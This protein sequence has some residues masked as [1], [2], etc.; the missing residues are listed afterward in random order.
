MPKY[1]MA[2]LLPISAFQF[3]AKESSISREESQGSISEPRKAFAHC[4]VPA[5]PWAVE[6][7]LL[8]PGG[9]I[10]F[11]KGSTHESLPT[12]AVQTVPG[13]SL[14]LGDVKGSQA[15]QVSCSWRDS[16]RNWSSGLRLSFKLRGRQNANIWGKDETKG[17]NDWKQISYA[18]NA[19]QTLY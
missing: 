13:C 14:D 9:Q 18:P 2:F 3:D 4:L 19:T 1:C 17:W 15:L 5:L 8:P 6:A 16:T 7:P 11:P 12:C 10:S